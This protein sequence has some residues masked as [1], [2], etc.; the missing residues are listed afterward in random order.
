VKVFE[1]KQ[2]RQCNFLLIVQL[3]KLFRIIIHERAGK[4]AGARFHN[5]GLIFKNVP[6][7]SKVRR[8]PSPRTKGFFGGLHIKC[9]KNQNRCWYNIGSPPPAGSKKVVLKFLSVNNM[10]I[11]L[12]L[13][14]FL[15]GYDKLPRTG[16]PFERFSKKHK[17]S[18]G[19][20]PRSKR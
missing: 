18:Q 12:I 9:P 20:C 10:V 19:L 16:A 5:V 4:P 3:L 8:H 6:A 7:Y 2:E 15:K 1:E 17:V 11:A 13:F 14:D